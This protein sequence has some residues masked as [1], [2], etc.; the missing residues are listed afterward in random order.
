VIVTDSDGR[1]TR[2]NAAAERVFGPRE[3]TAGKPIEQVARDIRIAQAVTDVLR[4]EKAV[5]SEGAGA[6]LPWAV[7]GAQRAFRVRRPRC[8]TPTIAWWAR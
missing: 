8:A 7:D 3:E 2:T 1:V 5:A 6:V 4:S